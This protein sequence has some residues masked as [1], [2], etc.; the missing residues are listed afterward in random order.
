MIDGLVLC[1]ITNLEGGLGSRLRYAY[2]SRRL[3]KCG[4]YF[5]TGSGF[6]MEG[7]DRIEIGNHCSFNAGVLIMADQG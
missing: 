7:C 5:T 2:Y 3:R 4:G 6:R 1:M